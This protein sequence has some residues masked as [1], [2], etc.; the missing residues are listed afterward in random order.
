EQELTLLRDAAPRQILE[1]LHLA[2]VPLEHARD[3]SHLAGSNRSAAVGLIGYG[4]AKRPEALRA[5]AGQRHGERGRAG[6]RR[7]QHV[8]PHAHPSPAAWTPS[9]ATARLSRLS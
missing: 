8:E 1:Q 2:A 9:S 7:D 5:E 6:I 3:R 4:H